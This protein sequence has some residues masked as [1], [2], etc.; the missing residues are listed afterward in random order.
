MTNQELSS[1][2]SL[3]LYKLKAMDLYKVILFGS[4]AQGQPTSGSNADVI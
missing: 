2:L 4:H 3:I 1:Y